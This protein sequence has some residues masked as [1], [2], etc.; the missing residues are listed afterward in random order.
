LAR[1]AVQSAKELDIKS[2]VSDTFTGRTVLYISAFRPETS[3]FGIC[4]SDRVKR[5]LMLS[6]GVF[7]YKMDIWKTSDEFKLHSLKLLL[8]DGIIDQDDLVLLMGGNFN[9]NS[10]VSFVDISNAKTLIENYSE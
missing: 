8:N 5:E 1:T 7:A 4:Y 9:P 10:G 2:I 3:I 6:Y